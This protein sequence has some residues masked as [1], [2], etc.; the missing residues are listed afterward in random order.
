[1]NPGGEA[2]EA[3]F[4]FREVAWG[5]HIEER[6][7]PAKVG[8]EKGRVTS[9]SKRGGRRGRKFRKL[10]LQARGG[11][12]NHRYAEHLEE[13][14]EEGKRPGS[15]GGGPKIWRL[16]DYFEES[17]LW[18]REKKRKG[19]ENFHGKQTIQGSLLTGKKIQKG[20]RQI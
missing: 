6:Y 17:E 8:G 7:F 9:I 3:S 15:R 20:K 5:P 4:S 14:E 13:E 18:G 1:V 2:M 11:K 19:R 16:F 10:S 12:G